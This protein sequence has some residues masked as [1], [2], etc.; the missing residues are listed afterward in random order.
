MKKARKQ[1][2]LIEYLAPEKAH[3]IVTEFL[4][5]PQKDKDQLKKLLKGGRS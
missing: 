5:M 4:G 2:F 3:R 1:Q